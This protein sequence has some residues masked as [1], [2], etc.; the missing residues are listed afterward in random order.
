MFSWFATN[1][2]GLFAFMTIK[3]S[4][5]NDTKIRVCIPLLE[6]DLTQMALWRRCL[7]SDNENRAQD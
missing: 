5:H 7:T 2:C 3:K 1:C 4:S 6:T